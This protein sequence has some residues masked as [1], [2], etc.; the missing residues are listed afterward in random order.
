MISLK[1]QKGVDDYILEDFSV[2]Q[3]EYIVKEL[4]PSL[5]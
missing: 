5:K 4:Y 1:R 3:K 2:Q